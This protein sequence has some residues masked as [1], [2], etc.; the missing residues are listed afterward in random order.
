MAV[1][2]RTLR[3]CQLLVALLLLSI[4]LRVDAGKKDDDKDEKQDKKPKKKKDIRDYDDADMERLFMEWE[5]HEEEHDPDDLLEHERPPAKIDMS[6]IDPSN[7]ESALKLTK[8]GKTLMLFVTVSG[9]PTEEETETITNQWQ[10]MLFNAHYNF[11]RYPVS[12]NRAIFLLTDGSLAW[13]IKDFLIE[14][15][16][17][18]EVTID[19]QV[20]YGKGS[21]KKVDGKGK[22]IGVDDDKDKD[23]K[24]DKKK[25]TKKS[26]PKADKQKE[27]PKSSSSK[28][29]SKQD[30]KEERKKT[31]KPT[32][33]KS[34]DKTVKKEKEE[35]KADT[36]FPQVDEIDEEEM[37]GE[38]VEQSEPADRAKKA[39]EKVKGYKSAQPLEMP[40]KDGDSDLP[41]KDKQKEEL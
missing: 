6:Q 39:R 14:Q 1:G 7:P 22:T 23:K 25:T 18:D 35:G 5:E 29:D 36:F 34:E 21:G 27:K 24:S 13:E 20:Y 40:R 9:N 16:R 10:S 30:S 17:C 12:S 32:K 37:D 33:D 4:C 28:H 2:R 3:I 15:D 8:K 26:P 41:K 38:H 19:S 11:K 31:V